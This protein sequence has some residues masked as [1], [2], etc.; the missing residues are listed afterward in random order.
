MSDDEIRERF[1]IT[2]QLDLGRGQW[3]DNASFV[4]GRSVPGRA[5]DL[6]KNELL[7]HV[8]DL[9]SDPEHLDE[10]VKN[11]VSRFFRPEAFDFDKAMEADEYWKRG[12]Y[13]AS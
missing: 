13:R 8:P 2:R 3:T 12:M 5:L 7:L 10:I 11:I 6:V 4:A 1:I 9:G